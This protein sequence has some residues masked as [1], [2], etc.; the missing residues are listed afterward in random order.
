MSIILFCRSNRRA[1]QR[2][3]DIAKRDGDGGRQHSGDCQVKNVGE[4]WFPVESRGGVWELL[5]GS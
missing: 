5:S 1:I 2:D 4:L 3:V